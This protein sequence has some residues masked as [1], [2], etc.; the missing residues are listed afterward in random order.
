MNRFITIQSSG[1]VLICS[2]FPGVSN[3]QLGADQINANGQYVLAAKAGQVERVRKLLADGAAVNSRD[4]LG[5]SPLNMAASK[6]NAPLVDLLLSAGA[7]ANLANLSEVTPLM[8]ACFV[9]R[10]DIVQKLL[11]ASAKTAPMDRVNKS[12][13]T[14]AAANGCV[15]CIEALLASGVAINARLDNDLTLLMW[16]AAYG[17]EDMVRFLLA[18]HAEKGLKD[19][20]GLTALDVAREAKQAA[21]VD[22]LS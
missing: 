5:N 7:D 9:G 19:N 2:L 3:A 17:H 13:A 22:L 15:G 1:F 20:R 21:I 8:G 4:R 14:Y 12:A 6:G 18:H 10:P 16:A 11:A